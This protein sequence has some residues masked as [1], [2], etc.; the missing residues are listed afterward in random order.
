MRSLSFNNITEF[1]RFQDYKH[2]IKN[3]EFNNPVGKFIL[4]APL[5]RTRAYHT[6]T[7][8]DD[9]TVL[10]AGGNSTE[11]INK[12]PHVITAEIYHPD[13]NKFEV[14]KGL[15]IPRNSH[16]A[17][18]LDNGKVLFFGGQIMLDQYKEADLVEE[19]DPKTKEFR[20]VGKLLSGRI[21]G[22]KAVKLDDGRIFLYG[23]A[24]KEPERG[25][26]YDPKTNKSEY[27]KG[28][29][30]YRHYNFGMIKLKD[31]RIM[32]IGG[33]VMLQLDDK[34]SSWKDS[35]CNLSVEIYDP[36]TETVE[37][38][39]PLRNAREYLETLQL[40][41]GEILIV[42][43]YDDKSNNYDID[44]YDLVKNE[45]KQTDKL[46]YDTNGGRV[47][48]ILVNEKYVLITGFMSKNK[49]KNMEKKD[50]ELAYDIIAKKIIKIPSMKINRGGHTLT[51]LKNGNIFVVGGATKYT[52]LFLI[53]Q[54][55]LLD[56]K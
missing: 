5:N 1:I 24:F 35:K 11:N 36:K 51:K 18:K 8:L 47:N 13:K 16:C 20:V 41:N 39:Y 34:I 44:I 9:G 37:L 4:S 22:V 12:Y 30:N 48:M 56:V 23:G 19:Y 21:E 29:F 2:E 50:G 25:E 54:E 28:K 40:P 31:N 45:T 32:I 3:K 46:I 17:V 52:E 55:D 27:T 42:G 49:Y 43:G 10:I 6:A 38:K 53:N 7:L 33:D 14:I 26:I 15:N